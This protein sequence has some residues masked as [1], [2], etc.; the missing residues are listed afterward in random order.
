MTTTKTAKR[1]PKAKGVG[2]TKT[3][4]KTKNKYEYEIVLQQ[5]FENGWEDVEF[6]E[7][8]SNFLPK[9]GEMK[10]LKQARKDYSQNAPQYPLR[11]IRRKT[12]IQKGVGSTKTAKKKVK[13]TMQKQ[14]E[15]NA[16]KQLKRLG[17]SGTAKKR[18]QKKTLSGSKYHRVSKPVGGVMNSRNQKQLV[19]LGSMKPAQRF[20][21]PNGKAAYTF[22]GFTKANAAKYESAK[23][24]TYESKNLK[25]NVVLI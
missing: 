17:L 8:N 4:A 10:R 21:F 15:K 23:G 18:V 2:S 9:E 11:S 14:R 5:R 12:K 22:K 3:P 1:K 24:E 6:F 25:V 16:A 19:Q 13:S 20:M 7:A